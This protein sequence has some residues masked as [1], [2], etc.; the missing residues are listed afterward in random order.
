MDY[1]RRVYVS[2]VGYTSY[3]TEVIEVTKSQQKE[4]DSTKVRESL[5]FGDQ[6][7]Q[8]AKR[9]T[10]K[11]ISI[12]NYHTVVKNKVPA[13]YFLNLKIGYSDIKS[14]EI[15][16]FISEKDNGLEIL[17]VGKESLTT[18]GYQ[19]SLLE[20]ESAAGAVVSPIKAIIII[21]GNDKNKVNSLAAYIRNLRPYSVYKG[22]GLRLQGEPL[23]LKIVVKN[24]Q[25]G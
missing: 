21:R 18:P 5:A 3:L 19:E 23:N 15:T 8:V 20:T 16:K 9:L 4:I 10:S 1:I 14:I 25:K 11:E 13:K 24:K 22:I 7:N 17:V 12:A 2:G 6:T